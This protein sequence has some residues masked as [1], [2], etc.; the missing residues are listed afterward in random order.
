[1]ESKSE[2]IV[3][4]LLKSEYRFIRMHFYCILSRCRAFRQFP[5]FIIC[6]LFQFDSF[7]CWSA[8]FSIFW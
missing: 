7:F 6:K 5:C 8:K 3:S 4:G 1:L 2:N